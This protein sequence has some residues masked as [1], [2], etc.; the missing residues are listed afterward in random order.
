MITFGKY[1][2]LLKTQTTKNTAKKT[3]VRESRLAYLQALASSMGTSDTSCS[4]KTIVPILF[5]RAETE[6]WVSEGKERE[7]KRKVS[8][9]GVAH[10]RSLAQ[11]LKVMRTI[12]T[13]WWLIMTAKSF[14]LVSQ[15]S[16]LTTP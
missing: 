12:V 3:V 13:M 8:R 15:N 10:L 16:K 7:R 2:I 4:R 1:T 5:R 6:K 14:L 11:W 9:G